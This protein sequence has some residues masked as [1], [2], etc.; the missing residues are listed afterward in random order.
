[1]ATGLALVSTEGL[2]LVDAAGVAVDTGCAPA[3]CGGGQT[4]TG[5]CVSADPYSVLPV[6]LPD[7][8]P[9]PLSTINPE[10][11]GWGQSHCAAILGDAS[12]P[13]NPRRST[14]RGCLS[15]FHFATTVR[16]RQQTNPGG[17]VDSDVTYEQSIDL[18]DGP[19]RAFVP[20][21]DDLNDPACTLVFTF[22]ARIVERITG[23]IQGD[24]VSQQV[25]YDACL[26]IATS[27]PMTGTTSKAPAMRAGLLEGVLPI[28]EL[29]FYALFDGVV[30]LLTG[31]ENEY[32]FTSGGVT[33]QRSEDATHAWG[34]SNAGWSGQSSWTVLQTEDSGVLPG[35][36]YSSDEQTI[37]R[38]AVVMGGQSC[39]TAHPA[40]GVPTCNLSDCGTETDVYVGIPCDRSRTDLGSPPAFPVAN[41]TTCRVW[42][43]ASGNGAVGCYIITPFNPRV[44]I[45]DLPVDTPIVNDLIDSNSTLPTKAPCNCLEGCTGIQQ[46]RSPCQASQNPQAIEYNDCCCDF[47]NYTAS[48]NRYTHEFIEYAAGVETQRWTA[49]LRVPGQRTVVDG[50]EVAHQPAL[51][52]FSS[53][54][55][56]QPDLQVFLFGLACGQQGWDAPPTGD[57]PP[58]ISFGRAGGCAGDFRDA[59]GTGIVR[60]GG[61]VNTCNGFAVVIEETSYVLGV[62]DRYQK[63][64]AGVTIRSPRGKCERC[65][66][67]TT[68]TSEGTQSLG[69]RAGRNAE[70]DGGGGCGSCGGGGDDGVI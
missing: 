15:D 24:D 42:T 40:A 67:A 7:P 55:G 28:D 29:R 9:V 60:V 56:V 32:S 59:N 44:A 68:G 19:A 14:F 37:F 49:S 70:D 69:A 62:I 13:Q 10:A 8:P 64:T 22:K 21:A 39:D 65:D 20:E 41:V 2:D 4:P 17:P 43:G 31:V 12:D 16:I 58:W 38:A 53:P 48:L 5:C 36:E 6:P 66:C 52:D 34:A 61:L 11:A 33:F 25:A 3:C 50:V 51:C 27:C 46:L 45:G 23:T 63:F 57:G 35:L 47:D 18:L 1:M 54:S 30:D 26:T